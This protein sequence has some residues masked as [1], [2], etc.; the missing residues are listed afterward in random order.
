MKSFY[1]HIR[2][3]NILLVGIIFGQYYQIYGKNI[4]QYNDFDWN[5]IQTQ[6]F[7]IYTYSPGDDHADLVAKESEEAYQKLSQL[8]DWRLKNRVSII[9]YNSHNDFQ[10]TNVVKQYM[11]EGIGGVTELYK[12][13]VVIPFDGSLIEFRDVLHHELL[14][15][16]INDCVYGGSLRKKITNSVQYN[17]PHWMNEG[18]AEYSANH[19]DANSDMWMRDIAVN[20]DQLLNINQL[21]GYLGYRGGQSV[22]KFI[23]SKWGDE[24]VAEIIF[25]IK[26]NKNVN[27]GFKEAIGLDLKSLN[28]QWKQYLKETYWGEIGIRKNLNEFS[29][30]L[31]NQ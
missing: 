31:K 11:Q 22:W 26:K 5:Y 25:Q 23:T 29:R 15:A 17:I 18:L 16:F 6:H 13:R 14:H 10:Q 12:N 1:I 28:E 19:W 7:D 3:I 27:A 20:S 4:V 8:L 2:L 30:Q 21:G 9:I 24:A